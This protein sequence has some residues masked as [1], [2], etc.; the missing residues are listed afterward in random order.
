MILGTAA[1]M[2]PEQAAGS[3]VDRRADIWSFGV[4]LYEM[5]TGRRLFDGESVSHVLAAVLKDTPD[6]SALPAGTPERIVNLLRRCLRKKPRERLQAIGDARVVIEEVL[7][8]P[9]RGESRRRRSR[10]AS[11]LAWIVAAIGCAAALTFATLWLGSGR[12]ASPSR[13][14]HASLVAPEGMAFGDTF[15]LSPDGSRIVFEAYDQKTGDA[16]PVAAR[17]RSGRG[18]A[19]GA[20]RR[21]GDAVLVPRR[22]PTSGSSPRESSSGSIRRVGRRR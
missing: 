19:A 15:A 10:R 7:A 9:A 22:E 4:V 8:D 6:F 17:A 2:A 13:V 1:Y 3:A 11:K 16:R 20:G 21:R 5:L 14:L 12:S 18:H